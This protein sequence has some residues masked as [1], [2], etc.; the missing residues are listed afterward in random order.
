MF[1]LKGLKFLGDICKILYEYKAR[2]V[3]YKKK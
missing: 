1:F 3:P 2:H